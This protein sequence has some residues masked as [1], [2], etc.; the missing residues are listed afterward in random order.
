[1]RVVLV[2]PSCLHVA[3]YVT[4][5]SDTYVQYVSPGTGRMNEASGAGVALG[6]INRRSKTEPN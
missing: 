3:L 4:A 1:V 5:R 2:K 6:I